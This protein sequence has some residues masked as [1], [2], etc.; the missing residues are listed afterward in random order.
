MVLLVYAP[1]L[2]SLPILLVVGLVFFVVPGGFIIVLGGLYWAV[3]S[4]I[5]VVGLGAMRRWR[6]HR[7]RTRAARADVAPVRRREQPR[8]EPAGAFDSTPM[9]L[10]L[11]SHRGDVPAANVAVARR[12]NSVPQFEPAE[13]RPIRD[14]DDRRYV[15]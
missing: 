6:A 1:V 15:A 14:S 3:S 12:A 4:L 8:F 9:P 10:A 13:L 11:A 5:G 2:V 7:A